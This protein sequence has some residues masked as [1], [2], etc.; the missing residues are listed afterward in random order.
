MKNIHLIQT[1]K[2]SRLCFVKSTEDSS[3]YLFKH[4][5]KKS[6]NF[7]PHN[8]YITSDEEIKEG[9]W[10]YDIELDRVEKCQHSGTFKNW[11]KIILT[12][13]KGLIKNRV[14]AIND[15]F[16]EYFVN[17]P[18]CEFVEIYQ[19]TKNY[20]G[21]EWHSEYRIFIP[22]EEPKQE[23]TLEE[24]AE[25]NFKD[26]TEK[27]PVPTSLWMN[28]K[29]LQVY[30]FV[31]ARWQQERMYSEE[32]LREAFNSAREFNSLDGVVDVHIVLPMGG[33]MSD[34]QPLHF[35]FEEWFNQYKK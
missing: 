22:Q 25:R 29:D 17:N 13:D 7:T 30:N 10:I 31:E 6:P 3:F 23:T 20:N 24:A 15:E 34:L 1:D 14:Q 11:K 26:K 21:F 33:D 9:N 27:I 35:T 28:S 12:T 19:D 5:I 16:L 2:I 4:A 32:D 18:D 8:L